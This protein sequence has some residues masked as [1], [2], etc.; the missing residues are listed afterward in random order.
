MDNIIERL[1]LQSDAFQDSF[2]ILSSAKNIQE[3]AK[4]FF[5]V[6]RGNLLV[7]NAAIFFKYQEKTDWQLLFSK[8][9]SDSDYNHLLNPNNEF[10]VS[11]IRVS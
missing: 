6:L 4:H 9:K 1:R 5:Q 2:N 8:Q 11:Q 3:L 10:S 7:V